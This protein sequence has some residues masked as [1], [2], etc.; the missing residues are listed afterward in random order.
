[1]IAIKAKGKK[2]FFFLLNQ[3]V[4]KSC[5]K[6]VIKLAKVEKK[7]LLKKCYKS[8]KK[9]IKSWQK[10]VKTFEIEKKSNKKS[11]SCQKVVKQ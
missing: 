5:Q 7:K 9:L 11:K 10:S 1:M 4:S 6:I 2:I 8:V 3:K